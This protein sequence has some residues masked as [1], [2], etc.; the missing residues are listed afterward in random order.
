MELLYDEAMM[1]EM[2]ERL[3]N[4]AQMLEDV[5]DNINQVAAQVGGEPGSEGALVG[6]AGDH[7][8]S[9]MRQTLC[10]SIDQI[11]EDYQKQADTVERELEQ[12]LAAQSSL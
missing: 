9:A 12:W 5:R 2:I 3:R 10:S 4:N 6:A 7:M 11:I 8:T 1:R